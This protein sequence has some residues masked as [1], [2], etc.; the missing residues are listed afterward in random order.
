MLVPQLAPLV[1][2]A[3][4][5]DRAVVLDLVR[6][7]YVVLGRRLAAA[8]LQLTGLASETQVAP[9]EL[10]KARRE[11]ISSGILVE[12]AR[13]DTRFGVEPAEPAQSLWPRSCYLSV[14]L[15]PVRLSARVAVL[16]ALTEAQRA[17]ERGPFLEVVQRIAREPD[18]SAPARSSAQTLLDQF[19]AVRP[20]FPV[21]PI[22]RLDALALALHLR[23]HGHPARLVFG[24]RLEPFRAHCWVQIGATTLNEA[25]DLAA[26]YSPVLAV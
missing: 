7:R 22:C 12:Q 16:R 23:R 20:W 26:G 6:D 13:P 11:L 21:K 4:V 17:L 15:P 9:D 3:P 2:L 14:P 8:A 10:A 5:R 1:F 25:H 19:A 18:R 24:V